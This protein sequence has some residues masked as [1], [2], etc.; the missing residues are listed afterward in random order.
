MNDD[1]NILTTTKINLRYLCDIEFIMGLI[2]IMPLLEVRHV[3]MKFV[4]GDTFVYD[5]VIL[6]KM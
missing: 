4:S 5:F 2:C 1:M 3:F 6:I